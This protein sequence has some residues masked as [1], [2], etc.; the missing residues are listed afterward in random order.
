MLDVIYARQK[1]RVSSWRI[2]VWTLAWT[3]DLYQL[4]SMQ[5]EVESACSWDHIG[6]HLLRRDLCG[7]VAESSL[8]IVLFLSDATPSWSAPRTLLWASGSGSGWSW[9]IAIQMPVC[10]RC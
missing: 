8:A 7:L 2:Q 9:Q 1:P 3:N 6:V 10:W 4:V 5:A